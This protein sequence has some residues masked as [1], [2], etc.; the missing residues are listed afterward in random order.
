[1]SQKHPIEGPNGK[2]RFLMLDFQDVVNQPALNCLARLFEKR[3]ADADLLAHDRVAWGEASHLQIAKLAKPAKK[4]TV[5]AIRPWIAG[6]RPRVQ[7]QPP[8][9]LIGITKSVFK[10][11][12]LVDLIGDIDIEANLHLGL[13]AYGKVIPLGKK[14]AQDHTKRQW[15]NQRCCRSNS[16]SKETR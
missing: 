4:E 15:K 13:K 5:R 7:P 11:P 16:R 3:L 1:M 14:Q 9:Q 12:E 2:K 6:T 10:G 8:A